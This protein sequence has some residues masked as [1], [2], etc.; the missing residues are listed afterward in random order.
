ML[1]GIDRRCV[2]DF[3]REGRGVEGEELDREEVCAVIRRLKNGK[4]VG[5]DG[6]PAEV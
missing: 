3:R 2:K 4:A 5:T 1:G 6:I